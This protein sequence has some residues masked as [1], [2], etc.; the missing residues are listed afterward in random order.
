[1]GLYNTLLVTSTYKNEGSITLGDIP[2]G[3]LRDTKS[4]ITFFLLFGMPSA[5]FKSIDIN[6]LPNSGGVASSP[7]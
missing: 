2:N 5:F 4:S 7:P 6:T 3:A 1:M